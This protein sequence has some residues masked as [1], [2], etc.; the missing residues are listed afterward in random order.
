MIGQ[1]LC[2]TGNRFIEF[3]GTASPLRSLQKLLVEQQRLPFQ[4]YAYDED[5][6]Q[7]LENVAFFLMAFSTLSR[8]FDKR[9]SNMLQFYF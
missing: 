3:A 9:L 5:K 8:Y 6:Y 2:I 1:R 4:K 7:A